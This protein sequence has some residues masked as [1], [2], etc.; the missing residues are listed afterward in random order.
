M[1]NT[2]Q[3]GGGV[4]LKIRDVP[5]YQVAPA[6]IMQ[7]EYNLEPSR[8][9]IWYDL[10]RINCAVTLNTKDPLFCP[11][12]AGGIEL[13]ILGQ[14]PQENCPHATCRPDGV[15]HNTYDRHGSWEGEPSFSCHLAADII[16]KTCT[17]TAG[18]TT[19]NWEAQPVDNA[20]AVPAALTPEPA[21]APV[22]AAPVIPKPVKTEPVVPDVEY[23]KPNITSLDG[24]CG[25]STR[26]KCE[27]SSYGP[28]CSAYGWCGN[29]SAYCGTISN[30]ATCAEDGHAVQRPP[31]PSRP[32]NVSPNG[33]CGAK[34]G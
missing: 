9:S 23:I 33:L 8:G 29:G 7:V 20:P 15:C 24:T 30:K 4:S 3:W 31:V 14:P 25:G 2:E 21:P 13:S 34:H 19:Y 18:P 16:V 6:G 32:L 17:H 22:V 26:Y 10:S 28:C 11:L 12:I 27:G 1:V 5:H